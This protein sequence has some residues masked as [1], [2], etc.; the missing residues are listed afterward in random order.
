MRTADRT[1]A[2]L[3]ILIGAMAARADA[4]APNLRTR[5][6]RL[7]DQIPA[8]LGRD[9]AVTPQAIP[10]SGPGGP[11]VDISKLEDP[12]QL[13][14]RLRR[15]LQGGATPFRLSVPQGQARLG[16]F[17]VGSSETLAGN[18]LVLEGRADLFGRV[19]GNVVTLDGDIVMHSG[20]TVTGDVLAIGGR[21]QDQGGVVQGEQ[22]S[23]GVGTIAR[24]VEPRRSIPATLLTN[25]AGLAGVL[26]TLGLLG[27]GVVLFAKP[28]LETISDT[29][30]H[31]FFRSFLTGL[32]A[33]ILVIPTFGMVITGLVLSVV[34]ILLVPFVVIVIPFL[35]LAAVVAGFLAVAHT[36][37]E[38]HLRRR[39]AA[40]AMVG[41]ANSY[42]YLTLGL[43]GIG[44][45]WLAWIAFGWVPVAGSLM[46][47]AAF[48]ATWLL[49]TAGFGACLLSRAGIKPTFA[50]RYVPPE[51]LTDEY[52]WATPQ[53]GVS[54]VKRPD[55]GKTP[56][57][58][59]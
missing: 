7:L 28:N 31:S 57:P 58:R 45:A 10:E 1:A 23:L 33:Q 26:L 29:V 27:F 47:A 9:K 46:F 15:L 12:V 37:G 17:S 56:R 5:L 30:S 18:L 25:A 16:D 38:T 34:G 41:S 22:R 3:V 14:Q 53:F 54:A 21:I 24:A 49:A 50:G 4:S 51:A 59:P 55:G 32:L 6:H 8:T 52:L 11:S 36:M 43:A 42:R 35:L 39:M 13:E 48:L 20:A 19:T 40:G 2:A 44:A